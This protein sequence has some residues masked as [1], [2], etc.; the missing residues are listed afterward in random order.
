M[1]SK[2]TTLFFALAL[3]WASPALAQADWNSEALGCNLRIGMTAEVEF[4]RLRSTMEDHSKCSAALVTVKGR[5]SSE[6]AWMLG[7]GHCIKMGGAY[8]GSLLV[9]APGEVI[10]DR[11][12]SGISLTLDTGN[13][14]IPR[15]CI[16]A[17]KLLYAT[18]T[19]TDLALYEL[20]ETYDTIKNKTGAEPLVLSADKEFAMGTSVVVA[21]AAHQKV[22]ACTIDK[23]VHALKES[24]WQWGTAYRLTTVCTVIPGYSGSP[25]VRTDNGEIIG[26]LGTAFRGKEPCDLHNP[27]ELDEA[28]QK[29]VAAEGQGY[30]HPVHGLHACL[31]AKFNFDLNAPGC[32]LQRPSR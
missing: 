26:V 6:R 31:D 7:A 10:H 21:S 24:K 11:N 16:D 2:P 23:K 13:R 22:Q 8:A 14:R 1:Y 3:L 5:A 18:L 28:G 19:G 4:S 15:V 30:F 27:C 32:L 12:L 25:V 29:S 17:T 9:P 20:V